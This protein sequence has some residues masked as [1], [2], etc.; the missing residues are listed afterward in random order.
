ME[1]TQRLC[2]LLETRSITAYRMSK[3]TGISERLIGYWKSGERQPAKDSLI[4]LADYFDVSVDYL[5]GRTDNPK[6]NK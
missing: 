1:F 2:D 5:L 3:D 6:V 4:K